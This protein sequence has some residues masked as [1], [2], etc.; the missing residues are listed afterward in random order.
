MKIGRVIGNIVA[1]R[2][3]ERLVGHKLLIL[4]TLVPDDSGKLLSPKG[5]EGTV[6][7]VDLVGAGVGEVVIF[8]SG[9]TARASVGSAPAPIDAAVIGIVDTVDVYD[10]KT[11]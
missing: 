10:R 9:S 5:H 3:D 1:T 4:R 11:P 2:K 8:C 7:A 6:V